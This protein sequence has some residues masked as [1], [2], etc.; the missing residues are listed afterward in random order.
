MH[1][2]IVRWKTQRMVEKNLTFFIAPDGGAV[3]RQVEFHFSNLIA[4]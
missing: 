2:S 3:R 1:L 4:S